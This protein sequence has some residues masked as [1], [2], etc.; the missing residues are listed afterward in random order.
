MYMNIF[1]I[2][3]FTLSYHI[4]TTYFDIYTYI[5]NIYICI[6]I[7]KCLNKQDLHILEALFNKE[8]NPIINRQTDDF[9]RTL[10]IF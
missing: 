10:K 4:L 3:D 8:L 2:R 6:Y 9:V 5:S 7:Y 1:Y